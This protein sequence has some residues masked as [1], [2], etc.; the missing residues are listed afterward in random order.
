MYN[1][2]MSKRDEFWDSLVWR[3][4]YRLQWP[5][6]AEARR[7][8]IGEIVGA[9]F[10]GAHEHVLAT[11]LAE[12][13]GSSP[14]PGCHDYPVVAARRR[15]LGTLSPEQRSAVE[16]LLKD[17]VMGAVYWPLVKAQNPVNEVN[18]ELAAVRWDEDSDDV[19]R[20]VLNDVLDAWHVLLAWQARFGELTSPDR[21]DR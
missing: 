17:A 8:R 1:R 12:L 10:V 11:S 3:D 15:T 7:E 21:D 13:D 4:E 18:L 9:A 6:D 20:V 14:E 16:T 5:E 19:E 2:P